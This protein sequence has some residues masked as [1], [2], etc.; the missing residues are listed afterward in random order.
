MASVAAWLGTFWAAMAVHLWQSALFLAFV[1][2]AALVLHRAP[3]RTTNLLYWT[4]VAKLLLPLP[5]LGPLA[6]AFFAS[7]SSAAPAGADGA[8]GAV[9]IVMY[10]AVL[11][12]GPAG[13]RIPPAVWL[14][15]TAV[16]LAGCGW[17][18]V[19]D[20]ARGSSWH[21]HAPDEALAAL[22]AEAGLS[23]RVRVS[24]DAPGPCARGLWRPV[25][26]LPE[27]VV[28]GLDAEELRATLLHEREHLERRDPL[29][30]AVLAAVRA[31]F[32]FY[33]PV[34]WLARRIRETTE[35]ACDEAVV[36]A[37][38]PA[39]T[40]CRTLA[41]TLQLGLDQGTAASPVGVLGHRVSF[42]RR[43][44]ERIRSERRFE[45]MLRH[46]LLV[47]ALAAVAVATSLLPIAPVPALL[48]GENAT[49]GELDKLAG[50]DSDVIL[51][52]P[53]VPLGLLFVALSQSSGVEFRLEP[54]L[55]ERR[56]DVNLDRM[57]LSEALGRIG[58]LAGV[59]YHVVDPHT[60][61]VLPGPMVITEDMIPPRLVS[62]VQPT[63]PLE[64]RRTR[65]SGK[66]VLQA[67]IDR[68]GDV[69]EVTALR[70]DPPDY[71]P[72]VRAAIEA[73]RRWRYEPARRGGVEVDAYFTVVVEFTL[74]TSSDEAAAVH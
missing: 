57:P 7:G 2:L 14:V 8:W 56:A 49:V 24:H 46:R 65:L 38:T 13:G 26:V 32:W 1:G 47:A 37:G 35:L 67:V 41:R 40:Y 68:H 6:Q 73:V 17:L 54:G 74:E 33:P 23:R 11:G 62:K 61:E 16:W 48:A 21:L 31:A 34:W 70:S 52:F 20:L 72:F 12:D 69:T 66:V 9:R 44:L 64:A 3:A 60:V 18:L 39:A 51:S 71:E 25:V 22:L 15:L 36:R 42:L 50:P 30:Y 59:R 29:R 53:R 45:P 19:R 63:Y 10:P 27:I 28:R 43:R 58:E 4:G 55:A 5:L